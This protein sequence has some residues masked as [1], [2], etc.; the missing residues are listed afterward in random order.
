MQHEL[1]GYVERL[2][3]DI[4]FGEE[5]LGL[6]VIEAV[7]PGGTFMEQEH[8]ALHFRKELWFPRLLDRQFYDAWMS[9]GAKTM[10]QRCREEKERLLREH[11]PEP[12]P[13]PCCPITHRCRP[14]DRKGWFGD[15]I[16]NLEGANRP[17]RHGSG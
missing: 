9:S 3:A 13:E 15:A 7:G 11:Q 1:I 17:H 4:D 12:L 14:E 16:V 2:M 8:T 5:A 6:E 10:G